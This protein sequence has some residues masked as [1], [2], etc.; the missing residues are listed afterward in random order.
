[1]STLKLTYEGDQHATAVREPHHNIVAIDCPITAKGDEFSPG[2]LLGLSVAGCMLLSMGAVAQR[3]RLDLQ[4]T[5]VD[6]RIMETDKPF[7]HVKSI[8]L[9]FEIPKDFSLIDRGKLERAVGLCPS[10]ASFREKT[11]IDTTYDYAV[12]RAA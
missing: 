1:M 9:N 3:D 11:T 2:N 4:G 12:A 8:T 6:I 10:K 7:P 5:V